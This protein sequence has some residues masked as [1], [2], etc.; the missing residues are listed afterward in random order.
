VTSDIPL[1]SAAF[2]EAFSTRRD[3]A[4]R[5]PILNA[6]CNLSPP[7][8][9]DLPNADA[10]LDAALSAARF[11]SKQ[12]A[13]DL[14][15]NVCTYLLFTLLAAFQ[16]QQLDSRD[17]LNA[18]VNGPTAVYSARFSL[19]I[20]S[21]FYTNFT[22]RTAI[23]RASFIDS[24]CATLAPSTPDLPNPF[25]ANLNQ[26]LKAPSSGNVT[27]FYKFTS[28]MI[29]GKVEG[30]EFKD[31]ACTLKIEE[32]I[33]SNATDRCEP[34]ADGGFEKFS[35]ILVPN[36]D[37]RGAFDEIMQNVTDSILHAFEAS[38]LLKKG[39]SFALPSDDYISA[40][41]NLSARRDAPVVFERSVLLFSLNTTAN[42]SLDI[43]TLISHAVIFFRSNART[44]EIRNL[45]SP[46]TFTVRLGPLLC[47]FDLYSVSAGRSVSVC[48][49]WQL[50][51][52]PLFLGCNQ[53][54]AT[55]RSSNEDFER[56]IRVHRCPSVA[57]ATSTSS[58]SAQL[59]DRS[60]FLAIFRC[61]NQTLSMSR[62]LMSRIFNVANLEH[63]V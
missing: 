14:C 21:S 20:N 22:S 2:V 11:D 61:A 23:S 30:I 33:V 38:L 54:A 6:G 47:C 57:P 46:T 42:A 13:G 35:C 27:N 52:N 31:S 28:C 18:A 55:D 53:L 16:V 43:N 26:C 8:S 32:R 60:S 5:S 34:S 59:V 19:A 39:A 41:K 56:G 15:A 45:V 51:S 25:V 48:L 29:G 24:S 63:L 9:L 37:D 10:L 7:L 17:I 62:I 1:S 58:I 49:S 50:N 40:P 3:W 12:P 44:A 36:G 4:E